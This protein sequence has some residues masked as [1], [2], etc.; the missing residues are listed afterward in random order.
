MRNVWAKADKLINYASKFGDNF[1]A[2]DLADKIDADDNLDE[3]LK[4]LG[5]T[6]EEAYCAAQ[7]ELKTR[8]EAFAQCGLKQFDKPFIWLDLIQL[9][10]NEKSREFIEALLWA[11]SG[12][13][14]VMPENSEYSDDDLTRIWVDYKLTLDQI[15]LQKVNFSK[16][17][18]LLIAIDNSK[19]RRGKC[20]DDWEKVFSV[21]RGK[22]YAKGCTNTGILMENLKFFDEQIAGLDFL[23]PIKPIAYYQF[24]VNHRKKIQCRECFQCDVKKLFSARNNYRIYEN[25]GKN[26]GQYSEYCDLFADLKKCFSDADKGLCDSAFLYLSNLAE[27][28]WMVESTGYSVNISEDIPMPLEIL[29]YEKFIDFFDDDLFEKAEISTR[30]YSDSCLKFVKLQKLAGESSLVITSE[31]ALN[32]IAEFAENPRNFCKQFWSDEFTGYVNKKTNS[33]AWAIIVN[34]VKE[35]FCEILEGII[36]EV[37]EGY[38]FG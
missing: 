1:D 12:G 35:R 26:F 31:N 8:V 27:W 29:I 28:R 16:L 15:D 13:W 23:T 33:A 2:D 24:F 38:I 37:F 25:N 17:V 22:G 20:S 14:F 7:N 36:I 19:I 32:F 30:A 21:L 3:C 5:M 11:A 9:C 4:R 6:Y 10:K 18:D 34:A